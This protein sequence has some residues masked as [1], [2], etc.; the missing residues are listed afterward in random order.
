MPPSWQSG[1]KD[2]TMRM[3]SIDPLLTHH[4]ALHGLAI[5][6]WGCRS[7]GRAGEGATT[8]TM[9]LLDLFSPHWPDSGLVLCTAS[10]GILP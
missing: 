9:T 4:V 6:E 1:G 5:G 7:H 3:I 8:V 10:T 2:M